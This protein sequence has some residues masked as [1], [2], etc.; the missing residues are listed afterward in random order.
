MGR[1]KMRK[2]RKLGRGGDEKR[3]KKVRGRW[4]DIKWRRIGNRT[5]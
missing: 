2:E 1:R 4:R 5:S 3:L